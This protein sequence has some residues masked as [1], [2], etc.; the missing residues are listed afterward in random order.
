LS[1]RQARRN[2]GFEAAEVKIR[3]LCT[4][5]TSG[6]EAEAEAYAR[7]RQAKAETGT[8]DVA[9]Y[10][11]IDLR[12]I[13]IQYIDSAPLVSSPVLRSTF[14]YIFPI[15]ARLPSLIKPRMP[16]LCP[17]RRIANIPTATNTSKEE[18]FK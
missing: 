1:T 2:R 8:N 7:H 11:E 15:S 6:S 4:I 13:R 16:L 3:H 9:K 17:P 5:G 18:H 14:L 10:A 12:I